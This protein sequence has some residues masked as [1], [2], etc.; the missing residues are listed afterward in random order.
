MLT[1][2]PEVR[3]EEVT[4]EALIAAEQGR[5]SL[6]SACYYR[7]AE[8]LTDGTISADLARRLAKMDSIIFERAR[9]AHAA[10]GQAIGEVEG[11][12]RRLRILESHVGQGRD[13]GGRIDRLI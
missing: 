7:R 5:W 11:V 9:V 2:S 6:V 1:S 10:I 13:N 3:L 8:W 4:H 12:A